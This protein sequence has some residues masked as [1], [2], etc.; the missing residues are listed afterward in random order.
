LLLGIHEDT[1][2]L[3]FPTTTPEDYRAAAWLLERGARLHLADEILSPEL[4]TPQVE[5]LHDLLATLKTSEVSGVRLSVAHA[6][7]P[8]TWGILPVWP[9]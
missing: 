9:I 7:R 5:L 2:R 8:G 3:L 4:T 1:G 6:S